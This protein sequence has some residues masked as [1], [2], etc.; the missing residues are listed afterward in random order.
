MRDNAIFVRDTGSAN[1]IIGY[2]LLLKLKEIFGEDDDA[3]YS[4]VEQ[5]LLHEMGHAL[6]AVNNIPLYPGDGENEEVVADQLAFFIMSDFYD[7]ENDLE[8]VVEHYRLRNEEVSSASGHIPDR[9]RAD[10]YLCWIV[11]KNPALA[12]RLGDRLQSR[13]CNSEYSNLRDAWHDRLAPSWK[14]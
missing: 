9:R 10:N 12:D 3:W 11:G 7:S 2:S 8:P 5:T 14:N 4:N 6:I 13:D 1:I